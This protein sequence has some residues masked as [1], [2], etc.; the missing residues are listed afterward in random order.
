MYRD[1]S[2]V[3][4]SRELLRTT[5]TLEGGANGVLTRTLFYCID[6][7]TVS[8]NASQVEWCTNVCDLAQALSLSDQKR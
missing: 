7:A 6:M 2:H 8:M 1:K 5:V 4:F 3:A